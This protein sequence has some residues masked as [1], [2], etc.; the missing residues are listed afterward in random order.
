[1]PQ[2]ISVPN[3]STDVRIGQTFPLGATVYADGVNFCLFSK[4][5]EKVTLLLFDRPNDPAPARTIELHRGQNRTF[6][7][8]HIFVEGLKAGQVYAY[9]VD[10]SHEPEKGHRFDPDKVLLD[11]YAKAIAGKDIYDRKAAMAPGD[12]CAQALRSVVVNTSV[13][14]W[15]D[16]HAPRTPYAASIIYELHVGG[17]TRNPNSGLSESKRGTYAGLIE[18]IPY[19]KE[20]GITAVELLPVHY[21]D[22]EDAQPGLTNYWGY[23]TISFFAPHQGYSAADDPLEVVD[24]FRDMVK[25]L[26]KAG[27]EVILD[28]VFNHTAEGNENGPTLSFRGIDNRTYYILDED[29]SSY[30]NYSGCGNSVKANHP[31]VGGLILDSLRYWVSEMHVDGFRFDLASVLVRDTKGVPLHGSEI[32]TA[33]IIW[34]IESDPI[35]AGTKLIAE[36]WDAAGLYSVGK[37]VELADWFAE[38]NGPFRD[39]V[40]RFVKGDNGAVPALASRLLGS[41]DI[42]Y[43]QD[44]DINRSI[45]FVTCH[46]GFTLVD[47]VSYNEKHNEANGEKNRDGTNDNFSWNCGVEGETDDPKINQLRLRQIKNFLTILFFSQGT[48]MLLMGDPVGRT[49]QGNN[50]GYCQD[51]ELS[52]FDWSGEET[53]SDETHFLRGIIALTQSLSLFLE[54]SLLPVLNFALPRFPD[55]NEGSDGDGQDGEELVY[56]PLPP[57][58]E[59]A[60]REMY[61]KATKDL[62]GSCVV[63][64]GVK[65]AQPD[66][67]YTSHTLAVTLFHPGAEEILHLIFNAYWEPLNFELPPLNDGLIWHRL[68]DTYLPTPLDFQEPAIASPVEGETYWVQ[69]R[70]SVVL[71][72]K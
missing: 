16:D 18:K 38:W 25:A 42:Y 48:P 72:A 44:T 1:M 5:A 54:E 71:M 43:R 53:H 65:L 64:H 32:A 36:A 68:V 35:L 58:D 7:Y 13:Y 21:F 6:Y 14:D 59:A 19:L 70:S 57:V 3:L 34:A 15:E 40:R 10:G 11:P 17:F 52:W 50:N 8:W 41:P 20:L 46:D 24:E 55:E 49:Q 9:R 28:V 26:H 31:V 2:L 4:H 39:D 27:I 29:K 37:F 47:L 66:W 45:N 60:L 51:N 61:L 69:P 12:N 33:N 67:S 23:S 30:S 22:P 56:K 62:P 63:W